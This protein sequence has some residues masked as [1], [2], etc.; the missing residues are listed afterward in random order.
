[1]I[2]HVVLSSIQTV[3]FA[4]IE[5]L[6]V[7]LHQTDDEGTMADGEGE[8]DDGERIGETIHQGKE[9]RREAMDARKGEGM[10]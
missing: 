8:I 10:K 3:Q 1:M 5:D 6:Q 9:T 4:D 7:V 2:T